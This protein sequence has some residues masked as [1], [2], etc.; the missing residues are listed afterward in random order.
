MT[1]EIPARTW[2]EISRDRIARNYRAI[3]DAVGPGVSLAPVVK[4]NAYGHGAVEVSRVL[5][6]EGSGW[7]AV[8]C[9]AEGVELR[10]AGIQTRILVMGGV[11]PFEREAALA[12]GLTPVIHSL[13]ELRAFDRPATVHFK[14]D[15]GMH[16]LGARATASE[17]IEALRSASDVRVEGLM[18]H[19]A[20][21]ELFDT[22]QTEEQIARFHEICEALRAAGLAPEVLH[23]SSTN[24]LAY[25]R[26]EGWHTLARP[27]LAI[28]GYISPG[29]GAAPSPTFAVEPALTWRARL[30]AVKDIPAGAYVGYDA[31]FRAERPMRIGI[32]AAGYADGVPHRLSTRGHVVA[33]GRLVPILGA[34]SM[35]LTTIDLTEAP[36]L[37][38]GDAVTLIGREG[39]A[40]IDAQGV[41]ETAG[42]I[43]YSVLCGI[44]NRVRRVYV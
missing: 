35:D 39:D 36:Q 2:A 5:T 30:V 18:S 31:R 9:V 29:D 4:A 37:S 7:L 28:Y 16:R 38:A 26:R 24:A 3:R 33:G 22:T 43:S 14:V 20:S 32:V 1:S 21:A 17:V 12:A 11:L 27:G 19:F 13:A 41:A 40:A 25:G 34:V 10:E 44:G 42:E 6:A 15:T 8:S 23:C